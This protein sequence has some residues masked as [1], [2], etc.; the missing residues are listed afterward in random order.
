MP[1]HHYHLI[2]PAAGRSS[3]FP[4]MRPKWM[5]THPNGN[6]MVA[7]AI[8]GLNLDDFDKIHL[9]Y[10]REHEE[11]FRVGAGLREQFAELN[12]ADKLN[13]IELPQPTAHQPET[14]AR[15]IELGDIEGPICIKDTD[16]YFTAKAQAGNFVSFYDLAKMSEVNP[17]NKSYLKFE[18]NGFVTQIAEKNIISR[19]FCTGLYGFASATEYLHYYRPLASEPNLYLSHLIFKML[20]E[21]CT[22]HALPVGDYLDWG[23]VRDWSR[24]KSEYLCIMTDL[25]GCLVENS[26]QHFPPIW[27]ETRAIRENVDVLNKLYDSGLV[28]VIITTSRKESFRDRTI[29]QLQREGIKYHSIIFGLLHGKR[30]LVNDYSKTNPYPSSVAINLKRNSDE[31]SSL[32]ESVIGLERF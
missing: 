2:I 10:L 19:F 27:G 14:I 3:R 5:L 12:L 7:E 13:L 18:E 26:A 1:N 32:L 22:F 25:D 6:L 20:L 9:V 8:R 24:F 29:A 11:Q 17:G 28:Q 15:A 23:T 30:V 31:L 21:D 16:N 4:N